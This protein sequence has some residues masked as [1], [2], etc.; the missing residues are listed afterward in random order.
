ME[1]KQELK[2]A[3]KQKAGAEG[4]KFSEQ[5]DGRRVLLTVPHESWRSAAEAASAA[6]FDRLLFVSARNLQDGIEAV[7]ELA[8]A[9]A[10]GEGVSVRT[11]LDGSERLESLGDLWAQADWFEQEMYELFGVDVEGVSREEPVFL[12][13]GMPPRP[14]RREIRA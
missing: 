7:A 2:A 9:S 10:P 4:W 6:G 5:G 14:L 13:E 11:R 3:L 8:C 12:R 1:N